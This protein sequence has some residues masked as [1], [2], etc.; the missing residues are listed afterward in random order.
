MKPISRRFFLRGLG[1]LSVGLPFLESLLPRSA[2]AQGMTQPQRFVAFLE[3]N[4][5]NMEKFF[6]ATPYGPLTSASF[7]GTALAPLS[8]RTHPSRYHLEL[9]TASDDATNPA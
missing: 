4:G 2:R 6:P 8:T 3:C 9:T 5:V 7:T 1:G